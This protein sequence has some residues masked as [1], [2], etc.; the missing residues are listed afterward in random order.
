M[1]NHHLL[2]H[3]S[4]RHSEQHRNIRIA[5]VGLAVLLAATV[6]QAQE[7]RISAPA[8]RAP[9]Q[10]AQLTP[11]LIDMTRLQTVQPWQ[12]GEPVK[13]VRDLKKGLEIS[14]IAP[15]IGGPHDRF[16][17]T[18]TLVADF[19]GISATGFVPPDTVGAV[20]PRHYIQMVNS[21][22]AIYDKQGNL[23]AGPSAI[24]SLWSGFGGPCQTQNH[25]DPIVRYDHLAD[26]WLIS[27]FA[28]PGNDLHEC[29]AIS[30]TGDPVNGGWFLYAFP[31]VDTGNGN[32]VFPDYPKIGVWPDGYYMGTQR[33]FPNAGLDIWVFERDKMLNGQPAQVVQFAVSAPSLFLMPSDLDGPAP[34]PGTPNFFARQVD[35]ER[36]GG[37]DRIEIFAFGVD[38]NNPAAST[39]TQLASLPTAPFDSVLCTADL[40]GACV[41]Q[42]G[43]AQRLE[44][45]TAWPMW[46]LQYRNFSSHEALVFNHTIDVDRRDHAGIRWY[47]LR[48]PPG[49]NWTI[50]QQGDYAPDDVHRWMGS[51]A[52]NR[53]GTMA[54]GYSVS[55]NQVF[56]GIRYASR[57]AGDPPG[58]MAQGEVT[59]VNGAGAQTTD[60]RRWGNYSSMDVDPVDD[61][62]FWYTTMYY[63]TTSAAGWKTRISAFK[64]P[65]C[66]Q[67]PPPPEPRVRFEY[68]AKLVCGL[69]KNPRD[70]RLARGFYATAINLH[71]PNR[72]PA[73]LRKK[74]ALTFPP[75]EQQPGKVLP[76]AVDKLVHDEALETDCMDIRRRLFPNGFPTPYI[77]GFVVI[78]SEQSLDVTAVYTST[79]LTERGEP[80]LHSSIDVEQIRERV[81]EPRQP[82]PG[83]CPDLVVR[84][85]GP[86]SV[87]CPSGSGS[88][89]TQVEVM[90]ANTGTADAGPF[91]L[92][93]VLD[94]AQ[95]VVVDVNSAGLGMGLDQSFGITTPPGG[96]CF[97][98]DCTITAT[99]DSN[100]AVAECDETNNTRSD[101]TP[102]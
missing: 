47:E 57:L 3:R 30:R 91:E 85:I 66:D 20:G 73:L 92:R 52:M 50:A 78:Q 101:T 27:Q 39:L 15:D 2:G 28:V 23:L 98:P 40:L 42:P 44:T 65:D 5:A 51:V 96:N 1:V 76:I 99:A 25:G 67:P 35:G 48:R 34:P 58:T 38:W 90:V 21:A 43:V 54:L 86:P 88:C 100:G 75:E 84:A 29:I 53:N 97:D 70:M 33:G 95:S 60:F 6:A 9:V 94:P 10:P 26:R 69:Q 74:L 19:D 31:T 12:P 68:A 32:P 55:S 89:V 36:F 71:N 37:G 83:Q 45:L 93:T 7:T 14:R 17:P 11:G 4:R 82:P 41:P 18:Q 81:H 72:E 46:R 102:G 61:C 16:A 49:G 22:F 77:K 79:A 80:G 62:T 59:L 13:Q 64:H 87:S 63:D 56:P 8:V 24:N